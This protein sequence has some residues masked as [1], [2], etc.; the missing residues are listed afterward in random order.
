MKI[1]KRHV[2]HVIIPIL[3]TL[4]IIGIGLRLF[5]LEMLPIEQNQLKELILLVATVLFING[6]SRLGWFKDRTLTQKLSFLGL[7]V[8]IVWGGTK[9]LN[10]RPPLNFIFS[11]QTSLQWAES[12]NYIVWTIILLSMIILSGWIFI[13]LKELI[14]VQQGKK[15]ERNFRLLCVFIFLQ[16]LY[17]FIGGGEDKMILSNWRMWNEIPIM[18][19]GFF[20]LVILF[21]VINGF[22]CKW[23]HYLNKNQK[24]GVFF[25]GALIHA[26]VVGWIASSYNSILNYTITVETFLQCLLLFFSIY[27]GMTL[28][29]ILLLLPSA[30]L[31]DRRIREIRTLQEL[32]GTIGSVFDL[33]EL[34]STTVTLC[35]KVVGADFSWIELKE[36][37]TYRLAGSAGIQKEIVMQIPDR[38]MQAIRQEVRHEKKTLLINDLTKNKKIM[39]MKKWKQK[40]GSL[41]A[42]RV[43]TKK[44][45]FGILYALKMDSFGFVEESRDLFQAFADQVAVA[46]DNASLV[47]VTIEQEVYRE[48]LRVAH[49][50]QMRLL[51]R[52]MPELKGIELNAFCVTANEIGG[53]FYDIIQVDKKR[54]DIVVGDVSGKGASAAFYMAELKGVIQALAPHFSSPKQILMEVNTF[55]CNHF[56]SDTF[57]TMV[58]CIFFPVSKELHFVRA[59]HPP[60]GFIRNKKISWLETHGLGLGLV[61]QKM[62]DQKLEEKELHLKKG[63]TIFIYT[64]GLSEARN[65]EGEEYGEE[66]L[67]EKLLRAEGYPTEKMLITVREDMEQFTQGVPCHDDITLAA[68]RIV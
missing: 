10:S 52:I 47:Q 32:S 26:L 15:T 30:G 46:L 12:T 55:L 35:R 61:P 37:S 45:D 41:L 57:A 42:A 17:R 66:R 48:E 3:L 8:C 20:I 14:Y 1:Y 44:K 50:A 11:D 36:D 31:M 60:V 25:F 19:N 68:L 2:F 7:F 58:Y 16:V 13:I 54:V 5:H 63:D 38:L 53:D 23:I 40:A 43:Q 29:G 21:A 33:K 51:P 59:G 56:E 62:F 27:S 28:L 39:E 65:P 34:T 18:T 67:T 22:R 24:I 9:I 6:A 64:D 4:S 49:E